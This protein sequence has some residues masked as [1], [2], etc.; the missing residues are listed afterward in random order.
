MDAVRLGP[1]GDNSLEAGFST[2]S[3]MGPFVCFVCS[4]KGLAR[5]LRSV[6]SKEL[7]RVTHTPVP[8]HYSTRTTV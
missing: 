8:F 6:T 7:R 2:A 1:G 4:G 5:D 3:L